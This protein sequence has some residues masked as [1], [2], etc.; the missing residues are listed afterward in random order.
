MHNKQGVPGLLRFE[1]L[2]RT[3]TSVN[4]FRGAAISLFARMGWTTPFVLL[5]AAMFIWGLWSYQPYHVVV[6]NADIQQGR[7]VQEYRIA[8]S[9]KL[10]HSAELRVRV[11]GLPSGSYQLSAE[12]IKLSPVG[13]ESIMLSIAQDLPRG[14]YSIVVEVSADETWTGRFPIQHFSEQRRSL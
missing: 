2:E 6:G 4:K 5:G 3:N 12:D 8:L 9:N 14:L 10:Y 13:R 7:T 11:L 1:M